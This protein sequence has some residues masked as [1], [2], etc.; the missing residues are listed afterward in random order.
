M[1]S[2][3]FDGLH[4]R[5]ADDIADDGTPIFHDKP[6]LAERLGTQIAQLRSFNSTTAVAPSV[7][8][9]G[10]NDTR[11]TKDSSVKDEDT[12][13]T[14]STEESSLANKEKQDKAEDATTAST[15]TSVPLNTFRRELADSIFHAEAEILVLLDLFNVV[16]GESHQAPLP[17]PPKT[18]GGT[19]LAAQ[20]RTKEERRADEILQFGIRKLQ[21]NKTSGLLKNGM[22][23]LTAVAD[24]EKRFWR[25]VSE[26]QRDLWPLTA[27]PSMGTTR[28]L[29]VDYGYRDVGSSS[30]EL[31]R[32]ELLRTTSQ[33]QNTKHKEKT[34]MPINLILPHSTPFNVVVE[35]W[36]KSNEYKQLRERSSNSTTATTTNH[37]GNI[38]SR[39]AQ[40]RATL[41]DSELFQEIVREARIGGHGETIMEDR[42]SVPIN[43][44]LEAVI[45]WKIYDHGA[46]ETSQTSEVDDATMAAMLATLMRLLL[47]RR[48]HVRVQ[49][50]QTIQHTIKRTRNNNPDPSDQVLRN[51][52]RPFRRLEQERTFRKTLDI[53]SQ[54]FA[55]A[56]IPIHVRF[57]H[58]PLDENNN[59]DEA[60]WLTITLFDYGPTV[61]FVFRDLRSFELHVRGTV[62]PFS[63]LAQFSHVLAE[64]LALGCLGHI[65]HLLSDMGF[66]K[67]QAQPMV[68]V[69][70]A[71]VRYGKSDEAEEPRCIRIILDRPQWLENDQLQLAFRS[72]YIY[73]KHTTAG[74]IIRLSTTSFDAR[75]RQLVRIQLAG[76]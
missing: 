72:E 42:V 69:I 8:N 70:T 71:S 18:L 58:A 28:A 74:D 21:L 76:R 51:A 66:D 13:M 4:P 25:A 26:L 60:R 44:R 2:L 41:F 27:G 37:D 49:R 34:G 59:G 61:R 30:Q 39:L 11:D 5:Q 64:E 6:S 56:G 15:G 17:L 52:V 3:R 63:D 23:R 14:E 46:K 45:I 22:E 9:S 50:Q 67:V 10:S 20:I 1:T 31:S 43:D 53:V 65:T 48:H 12:V 35:I 54:T 40:A 32:A 73:K 68:G 57:E 75:I 47:R 38:R 55:R 7:V 29:Q 16:L 62:V 36:E 19:R 24:G 33:T